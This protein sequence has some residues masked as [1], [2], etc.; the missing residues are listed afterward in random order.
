[1]NHI[2]ALCLFFP[3]S[4]SFLLERDSSSKHLTV[5]LGGNINSSVRSSGSAAVRPAW[6]RPFILVHTK[7]RCVAP[8]KSLFHCASL[9]ALKRGQ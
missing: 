9:P 1:M 5:V 7:P 2:Q 6:L 4:S 3:P 8:G